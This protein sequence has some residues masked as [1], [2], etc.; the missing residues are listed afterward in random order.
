[1]RKKLLKTCNTLI[2]GLLTILG[3]A[4]SCGDS[5]AEYGAPSAKFIVN[6]TVTSEK[7]EPIEN[8]RVTM[9][10]H[11]TSTDPDGFYKVSHKG[12]GAF[13]DDQTFDI[14]FH[15]I[16]GELNGEYETTDTMVVFKDPE[17]T[18]G[19]GD[20]YDGETT[21]KFDVKLTKKK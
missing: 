19:D 11:T 15:D 17:F 12:E 16:D 6:G 1:M 4:S 7:N 9:R 21:K 8:I 5:L 20:W 14:Q 18:G 2:A 10:G 3:F 13:P